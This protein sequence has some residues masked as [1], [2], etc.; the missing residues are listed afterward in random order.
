MSFI[1]VLEYIGG[2][3]LFGFV[4]WLIDGI[5]V[6]LSVISRTGTV[7]EYLMYLWVGSAIIYLI[8][9]GYWVVREYTA[10]RYG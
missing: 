8:F 5:L 1:P 9:G 10:K 4:Y 7:Y 2:M 6:E 3:M